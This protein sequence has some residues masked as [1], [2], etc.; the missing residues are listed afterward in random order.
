M[1]VLD[2]SKHLG[3]DPSTRAAALAAG[4]YSGFRPTGL[5]VGLHKA[6]P[7]VELENL[8]PA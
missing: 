1:E 5:L 3:I 6:Q 2:A 4:S 8:N 7:I